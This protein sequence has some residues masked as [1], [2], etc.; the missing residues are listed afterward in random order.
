MVAESLE[1][2]RYASTLVR[3]E[4]ERR[5][6]VTE[7]EAHLGDA[8]QPRERSGIKQPPKPRGRADKA[9]AKAAVRVDVEY[10]VSV[11]HHNPMEMFATTVVRDEDGS[12]TVYDKTQG[13]QNVRDYLCS[14]FGVAPKD[15]RVVFRSMSAGRSARDCGRS[16][17]S[18]SRSWRPGI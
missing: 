12:L 9:L 3:V 6:H 10:R 15:L 11:E 4:Y 8:Y 5:P 14:V 7:L 13:V 1:L 2:A 16:T 18:S 17:R